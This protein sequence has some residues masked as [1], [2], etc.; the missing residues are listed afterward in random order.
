MVSIVARPYSEA[1]VPVSREHGV[2]ITRTLYKALFGE[3][4]ALTDLFNRGIK[5]RVYSRNPWQQPY[6]A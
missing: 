1:S 5:P 2:M 6:C 4:P 3:H